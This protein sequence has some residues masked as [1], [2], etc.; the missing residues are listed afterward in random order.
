MILRAG[1]TQYVITM[2]KAR[3]NL[4]FLRLISEYGILAIHHRRKMTTDSGRLD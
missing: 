4:N 3:E 2:I 1:C